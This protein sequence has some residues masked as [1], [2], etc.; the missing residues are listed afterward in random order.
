MTGRQRGRRDQAAR[1]LWRPKV[2]TGTVKCWRCQLPI[3]VGQEWDLGHLEDLAT[4]GSPTGPRHP[5]H[6]LKADCP[7]G[8]NRALGAELGKALRNG[9]PVPGRRSRR[10]SAWLEFFGGGHPAGPH[11]P[12]VFLPTLKPFPTRSPETRTA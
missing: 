10:L 5:E 12:P 7:A 2:A 9:T 3:K 6:R 1:N 11:L 8:G 4:G